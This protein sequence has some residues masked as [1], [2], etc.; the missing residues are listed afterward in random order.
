MGR[1]NITEIRKKEVLKHYAAVASKEGIQRASFAK[2]A[3]QMGVPHTLL[4]YYFKT[5]ENMTLELID[6]IAEE[7]ENVFM[8]KWR[9][10]GDPGQR[11][12]VMLDD[13]FSRRLLLY[14]Q[15]LGYSLYV[16]SLRNKRVHNRLAESYSLRFRD[17]LISEMERIA[18]AG[19]I[20]KSNLAAAADVML[21][22]VEGWQYYSHLCPVDSQIETLAPVLKRMVLD[23]LK[24]RKRKAKTKDNAS[25]AV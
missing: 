16:L 18:E 24:I 21:I 22:I 7:H 8:S 19:I 12:E 5:K 2:I 3:E 23:L 4:I 14:P 15:T 17:Y 13:L 6:Y 11:L 25:G 10:I 20:K 9:K 1:K